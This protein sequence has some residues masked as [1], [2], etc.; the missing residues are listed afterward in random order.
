MKI[1]AVLPG[2]TTLSI[3]SGE[4]SWC[5][6]KSWGLGQ[7]A[8]LLLPGLRGL[9][10]FQHL[11]LPLSVEARRASGF[12]QQARWG[13]A[14]AREALTTESKCREQRGTQHGLNRSSRGRNVP[15]LREFRGSH[16]GT[17]GSVSGQGGGG[18]ETS[19][20][21]ETLGNQQS[22]ATA[23][24]ESPQYPNRTQEAVGKCNTARRTGQPRAPWESQKH[25]WGGAGA[26]V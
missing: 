22:P 17:Q 20:Q 10:K 11:L 8:S 24:K 6:G 13:T 12:R 5:F 18:G 3:S 14:K 4:V 1:F 16:Q 2:A 26:Q 19:A 23:W 25:S 9:E 15:A 21:R 7:T